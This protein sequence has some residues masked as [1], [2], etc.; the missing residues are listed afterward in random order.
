MTTASGT[1]IWLRRE[2]SAT[3]LRAP[4]TPEDAGKL[5]EAGMRVTVEESAQR[6]FPT[7]DYS[8]AGA[9]IVPGDSWPDASPD[10]VILGLK[11]PSSASVPLAHRH[12]FFGHA[13][14]GQSDGKALLRRFTDGGGVLFDL[15]YLTDES[16]RRVAAFGYWAGYV[17]AALA[18]LHV[19]GE[20]MAP[21]ASTTLDDLEQRLRGGRTDVR[22]LVIGAL[23]RSGRGAVEA[24]SVAGVPTTGWDVDETRD[25]DRAALLRHD[26][27]VNAVF[28]AAPGPAFLTTDDL[29]RDRRLTMVADVTCD[30]T[31]ERN[32][33]PVN[34]KATD[35]AEPVRRLHAGPPPLDILAIDN[36]PS[37]LPREASTAFSADLLPHLMT[38]P[39]GAPVWDRCLAHFRAA[40]TTE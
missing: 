13:Y 29:T 40:S 31:P 10:D 27:L 1:G 33:L 30:F 6:V 3:E 4:L 19:R 7:S 37:L 20:L 18:V 22:A 25:L 36:L 2:A 39:Q 17:G 24:L 28:T 16:G 9:R 21:L 35:W 15:E 34:D 5:V 32:R 11:T 23:G 38:L 12:I 14:H 26:L 8:A